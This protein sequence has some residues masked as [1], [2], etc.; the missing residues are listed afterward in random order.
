M[1]LGKKLCGITTKILDK[2]NKF[3]DECC[4]FNRV[5]E[6][7]LNC[8]LSY[9]FVIFSNKE[10]KKVVSNNYP[11]FDPNTMVKINAI[12]PIKIAI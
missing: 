4:K 11:E 5:L 1:L 6:R 12:I 10:A 2:I 7:T 9:K 3:E 8:G